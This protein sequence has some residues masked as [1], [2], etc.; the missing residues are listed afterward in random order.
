MKTKIVLFLTLTSFFACQ[1]TNDTRPPKLVVGIVV[2]QMRMDYLTRFEKHYSTNGFMRFY[3]NGF[4]A[5]NH[6]F[7]HARTVTAAGHASIATGTPPAIHGIIGNDWFDKET[8]KEQYCVGDM[9]YSSVGTSKV[10][11]GQKAPTQLLVSTFSDENRLATQLRGKAIGVSIKDRGAI[12]SVGHT[13]NAAYWFSGGDDGRF[14]SSTFFMD[15]MPQWATTFNDSRKID[16]YLTTWDS[17][18]PIEDYVETGPDNTPYEK[19]IKGKQTPTFPYDL[20]GLAPQNGG[21][22]VLEAT[23]YGNSLITDFALAALEGEGLG[24]DQDADV[25]MIS[26]S[27]TD[28]IGHDFGINAKELQ[29]T[30]IRL[31]LDIARLFAGLDAQVGKGNYTVF[32]TSDHGVAQVPAYLIDNKIPAG[33]F[34]GKKFVTSLDEALMN[35]FDT[36]GLIREVSNN[37]LFLNHDAIHKT[38]IDKGM[39]IDFIVSFS[40][41][42]PGIAAAYDTKTLMYADKNNP[43]INRLQ[44]GYNTK[45]SGDVVFTL[46]PGYMQ[47]RSKG[48]THGSLYTYDTHVPFLMTGKGVNKGDSY[49]RTYITDIAPTVCS[50]MGIGNPTGT[51]GNPIGEAIAK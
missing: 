24:L 30:Y 39:L 32:L 45:R 25:L 33:Y 26:Y 18:Y 44:R 22:D 6:H 50:I 21:Y 19:I 1:P 31:D 3:R 27:S 49:R 8:G 37:E 42:Y 38:S 29:D 28:Y 14:V 51:I 12:L 43:L 41:D 15:K 20:A 11:V 9:R 36:K 10:R 7:D 2:D 46:L 5:Q 35:R 17:Y 23:P 16:Q 34:D 48:T 40:T 13:A 47:K 4:V